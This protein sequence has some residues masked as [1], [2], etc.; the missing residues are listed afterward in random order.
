MLNTQQRSEP[1]ATKGYDFTSINHFS[2]LEIELSIYRFI[3]KVLCGLIRLD[4]SLCTAIGAYHGSF[5]LLHLVVAFGALECG[6]G[7]P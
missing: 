7:N 6:H 2:N 3:K 5:L 4:V 1:M